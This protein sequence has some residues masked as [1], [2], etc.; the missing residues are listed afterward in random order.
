LTDENK[1]LKAKCSGLEELLR[2]EET[3]INDVLELIRNMQ[4]I[5][6]T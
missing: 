3:D 4:V 2:E 1:K 5:S 6:Q